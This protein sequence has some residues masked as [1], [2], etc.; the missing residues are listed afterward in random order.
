V[1]RTH[2]I[3]ILIMIPLQAIGINID[4]SVKSVCLRSPVKLQVTVQQ[5]SVFRSLGCQF[6]S[7]FHW[8]VILNLSVCTEPHSQCQPLSSNLTPRIPNYEFIENANSL[9]Q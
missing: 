7:V 9:L 5:W 6:F 3:N 1:R 2:F 4:V 8:L